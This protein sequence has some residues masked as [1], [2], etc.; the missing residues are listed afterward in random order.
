MID[1]AFFEYTGKQQ[2][3]LEHQAFFFTYRTKV[4]QINATKRIGEYYGDSK[5]S[6]TEKSSTCEEGTCEEGT[7]EKGTCEKG[8]CE[9]GTCEKGTCEK[10]TC[11]KGSL[12]RN[13]EKVTASRL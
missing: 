3:A 7:C 2:K 4:R 5:E 6:S 13:K 8:T 9:K 10:G 1:P 11:E 12:L